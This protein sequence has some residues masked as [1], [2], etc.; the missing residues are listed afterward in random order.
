MLSTLVLA[1]DFPESFEKK[2]VN[3]ERTNIA[4]YK[5]WFWNVFDAALYL[6]SGRD[7]SRYLEEDMPVTLSLKF[8]RGIKRGI[9]VQASRTV[10]RTCS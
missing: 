4:T 8:R 10:I 7:V 5:W 6:E 3:F 2:E 1:D 9:L